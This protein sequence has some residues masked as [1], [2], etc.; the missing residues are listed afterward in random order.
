MAKKEKPTQTDPKVIRQRQVLLGGALM[1][2]ALLL[3]TAFVSYLYH[4]KADYSTLGAFT[5]KTVEAQNLLNKFGALV[6]H[7]F[8]SQG[9][10]LSS[11]LFPY[12]LGLSGF[13]L[14]FNRSIHRLAS[15][16]G[17]GIAHILW[18]SIALGYF[19]PSQRLYS[20]I[21]GYEINLFLTIYI[22]RIGIFAGLTFFFLCFLVIELGWTP[23]KMRIWWNRVMVQT[24]KP[25]TPEEEQNL[26]SSGAMEHNAETPNEAEIDLS[27]APSLSIE[28]PEE[29]QPLNKDEIT[30]EVE[31]A[32]EE[33]INEVLANHLA[34]K[35]GFFDPTLELS[36]FKMPSIEL[37]KDYGDKGITINQEELEAN[38]NKIV[39]TLN[40]YK[41][42]ISNIKATIG[43]YG[44]T[45]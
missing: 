10:G 12:L 31:A 20:G 32:E 18:L 45:L 37:L 34:E 2:I 25:T 36:N 7:F 40:N 3:T 26:E 1:L 27:P 41:I 8:V 6:S 4:W 16:W 11:I 35:Q 19:F 23:E 28:D 22:G 24:K 9:V 42:G 21:I 44:D 29:I 17:W 38:K 30:M 39:E 33:P 15:N 5:D 14:F 13:Q 43:S